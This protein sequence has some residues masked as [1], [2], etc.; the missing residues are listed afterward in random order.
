MG[1]YKRAI[2]LYSVEGINIEDNVFDVDEVA[3]EYYLH[4]TSSKVDIEIGQ[5]SYRAGI[6]KI[7]Y[8]DPIIDNANSNET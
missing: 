1:G 3:I 2:A 8:N 7:Y 6:E 4:D 5:N